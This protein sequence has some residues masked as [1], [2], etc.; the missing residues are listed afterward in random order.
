VGRRHLIRLAGLFVI[1]LVLAAA[2]SA[3]AT[4][5]VPWQLLARGF[6]TRND[7]AATIGIIAASKAAAHRLVIRVSPVAAQTV[8]R[9]DYRRRIAL[10]IF[11]EFG[12]RDGRVRIARIEQTA[13]VLRVRLDLR[14][15][16]M[17]KA[18]CLAIY[19]TFRLVA[20]ERS[21]LRVPF[22]TR[23]VVSLARA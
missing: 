23:V 15:L 22:P 14:P 10:G 5:V 13:T 11:G 20:I 4:Q 2:A 7:G 9:L 3:A 12:C 16:G 21:D 1:T 18:E 8:L 6:A 19:P 17:G